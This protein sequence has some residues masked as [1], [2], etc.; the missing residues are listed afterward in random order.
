MELSLGSIAGSY[1]LLPAYIGLLQQT[2][3]GSLCYTEH[4]DDPHGAMRFKYQFIAYGACVNGYQYMRK[5]VVVDAFTIVDSENDD[6]W[7]WF[8]RHLSA[9][10]HDTTELVFISVRHASIYAGMR[11]VYNQAHHSACTVHFWR[12]VRHLYKP[13]TL[14]GLMFAAARAFVVDDFNK[15]FLEIQRVNPGCAAYLVDIGKSKIFWRSRAARSVSVI[16]PKCRKIV[17][18]NF[19]N[20]MAMAVRPISDFEFQI[21]IRAGECYT[22]KLVE[23]TCS[24]NEFQC[25]SIPCAHAIA[26]ATRLGV[27]IENFID[28]AYYEET[29]RHSYEEKITYSICGWKLFGRI[30]L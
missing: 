28:V 26:A 1:A 10:V 16:A 11:K 5:V 14:A 12:N 9:F 21:Q 25:L 24:C 8:F 23:G 22:V 17:D 27:S 7:E 2:N 4:V 20:A 29:I 6:A 13:Q 30:N 19:E 18:E 15:K 3:P